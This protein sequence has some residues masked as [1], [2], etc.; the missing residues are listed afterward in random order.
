MELH[1]FSTRVTGIRKELP[2]FKASWTVELSGWET[3]ETVW[4]LAWTA[5]PWSSHFRILGSARQISRLRQVRAK[6]TTNSMSLS[7][8][9]HIPGWPSMSRAAHMLCHLI[10]SMVAVTGHCA[11]N[12]T[13]LEPLLTRPMANSTNAVLTT[14][15]W[16]SHSSFIGQHFLH[17]VLTDQYSVLLNPRFSARWSSKF[18][19]QKL[20]DSI[21][22]C[23]T[24][25][26][27]YIISDISDWML[28]ILSISLSTQEYHLP[29]L[30]Y[31][32]IKIFQNHEFGTHVS[33][34]QT[35]QNSDTRM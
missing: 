19:T 32:I 13:A 29:S 26:L 5:V 1:S 4:A 31:F 16:G 10:L 12:P 25:S 17:V 27:N 20:N 6:G 34:W 28:C 35:I 11:M 7:I 33:Q 30:F 2:Q 14:V 15:E 18:S 9:F 21:K 3:R 8:A 22:G 24:L 23:F